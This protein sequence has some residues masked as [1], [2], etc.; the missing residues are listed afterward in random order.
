MIGARTQRVFGRPRCDICRGLETGNDVLSA[1]RYSPFVADTI[2]K[3]FGLVRD[4]GGGRRL[5]CNISSYLIRCFYLI[6]PTHL[7]GG[8][9]GILG[10]PL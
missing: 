2:V 4:E 1:C 8:G 5:R 9:P 10:A 6:P 3:A 7:L